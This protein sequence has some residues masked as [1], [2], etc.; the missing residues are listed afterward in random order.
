MTVKKLEL[1]KSEPSAQSQGKPPRRLG[2][3]GLKLWRAV[4][5]EYQIVD[6]GGIEML[7]SA[8]QA[9]DRA[10]VMREQIDATGELIQTKTGLRDNPLLKHELAARAFVVRT[11]HKLGLDVEA[12]KPIGRPGSP[13]GISFKD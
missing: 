8:C 1:V 12:I 5:A 3:H 13:V 10:E 6:A 2:E 7:C 11:L 9:L 4:I